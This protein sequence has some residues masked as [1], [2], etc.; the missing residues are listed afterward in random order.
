MLTIINK[1]ISTTENIISLTVQLKGI[2]EKLLSKYQISKSDKVF[3]KRL[4]FITLVFLLPV[5]P[6]LITTLLLIHLPLVTSFLNLAVIIEIVSA[7]QY[8]MHI[9]I[10]A[11]YFFVFLLSV[12]VSA[13]SLYKLLMITYNKL[14]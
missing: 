4:F 6:L 14:F 12:S 11:S 13:F 5:I 2:A 9:I 7:A 8:S 1:A 10:L 3:F